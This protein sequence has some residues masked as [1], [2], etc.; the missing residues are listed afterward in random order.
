MQ[1]KIDT[2]EKF[3]VITIM[4]AD[5]TANMTAELADSLGLYL[6]NGVKNVILNLQ[7]VKTMALEAA[8]AVVKVQQ[9]YYEQNASF[10]ICA[11]APELENFLD[12]QQLL[13]IMSATPTESEAW[14]IVQMEE[15]ERELMD[16]DEPSFTE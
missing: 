13:E 15:I 14:D 10:V 1:V 9:T 3:H 6:Q 5:L 2:K 11:I 16:D 4:D 7:M 12:E 8:E